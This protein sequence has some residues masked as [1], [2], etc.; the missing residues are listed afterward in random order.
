V[1]AFLEQIPRAG[2]GGYVAP[3]ATQFT[4][5]NQ[6]AAAVQAGRLADAD[7]LLDPLSYDV[8]SLQDTVS[9]RT[10]AAMVER[11]SGTT[12][13]HAW[14]LFLIDPSAAHEPVIEVPHPLFDSG[15]EAMGVDAFRKGKAGALLIA[16][17]HR[18]ATPDADVAHQT[19]S[20]FQAV[21]DALST[22]RRWVLQLHGFSAAGHPK[23][24]EAVVSSGATA[25]T[26]AVI[27]ES[28]AL[29]KAGFLVCTY[30]TTGCDGLGGTTNVQGAWTRNHGGQFVHLELS[31]TV[32]S[33]AASSTA[34]M[35]ATAAGL[36]GRLAL[37]TPLQIVDGTASF[38]V[39]N[40]GGRTF[41]V[42]YFLTGNRNTAGTNLDYPASA[43][44]SVAPGRTYSY[45][46]SRTLQAG[47]YTAWAAYFK[48][49]V[50]TELGSHLSY[51]V[52]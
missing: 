40:V 14:G 31:S 17:A 3:T 50:W 1:A 39:R 35:T 45:R 48:R 41:S 47:G 11:H 13:Q 22:A 34:A 24:G 27:A 30:G 43:P 36:V 4:T 51:I 8:V 12:W 26:T 37:S 15:T 23:L 46:G 7:A 18:A 2:Q 9:G 29:N 52:N 6:A 20:G 16:G 44:V 32:R 21:H 49:G 19:G 42:R 10:V 28:R 38:I 5:L 33:N 25:S